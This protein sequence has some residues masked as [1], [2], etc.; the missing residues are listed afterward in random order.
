MESPIH[1]FSD[2]GHLKTVLLKRPGKE[3]ENLTPE[4][5]SPLLF[6]DIPFYPRMQEEH[7]QFAALLQAEEVE[8]LYLEKLAVE[9]LDAGD[10]RAAFLNDFLAHSG[11][12]SSNV[13]E[14]LTEYF[15]SLSTEN[16]VDKLM[17]GLRIDELSISSES[18]ADLARDRQELFYLPPMPNLYFTRD[19]TS[20]IGTNM[21]LGRMHYDVR[22]RE[23][24]FMKLI[25]ENHPRFKDRVSS[26]LDTDEGPSI[27]GGDVLVLSPTVLAVG[28]SQRTTPQAI[29]EL[30]EHLFSNYSGFEK[31]VAVKIPLERAMMHLDTVLTMVD[32]D[33]FTIHPGIMSATEEMEIFV[34]E[35]TRGR[36]IHIRPQHKLAE[37]LKEVLHQSE[38][39]LIPCGGGDP[40]AAP[41]EQWN[42]GSNTLALSPGKVITYDRNYVSNQLLREYGIK[43]LEI[44]SSELSRGRGGPRCMSQAIFRESL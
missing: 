42:D 25:I 13:R 40:I 31:I 10:C 20:S 22:K 24:L 32:H 5:L 29:Q 21:L 17:T 26:L 38:L 9:A 4:L 41:R 3:I 37:V 1:V 33:K 44:A 39:A 35:Q 8:V 14:A 34:L 28:I 36:K 7:D 19:F 2:I 23:P 12:F 15:L 27:E 11:I 43:V 18:L 16:F 30:A 6:D